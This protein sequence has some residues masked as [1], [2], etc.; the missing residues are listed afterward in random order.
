M[1]PHLLDLSGIPLGELGKVDGLSLA[2]ASLRGQ[3]THVAAPLCQGERLCQSGKPV[4]Y[5][6]VP[7][8]RAGSGV[9]QAGSG[10]ES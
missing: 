1:R 3:L 9:G 8:G 6:R 7:V 4:P 2:L 5:E 10:H